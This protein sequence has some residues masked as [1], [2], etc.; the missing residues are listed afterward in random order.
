M[1]LRL[2]CISAARLPITSDAVASAAISRRH[3]GSIGPK[4][5][6]SRRHAMPNTASFGAEPMN[7]VIAVGAP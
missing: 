1:R 5:V 2:A 7:S 6:S 3:S 4:P